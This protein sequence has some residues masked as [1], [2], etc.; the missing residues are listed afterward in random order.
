MELVCGAIAIIILEYMDSAI[1]V[2]QY[3]VN[4]IPVQDFWPAYLVMQ[5]IMEVMERS[6]MRNVHMLMELWVFLIV[7]LVY[8]V[9]QMRPHMRPQLMT[10]W[11]Y[12]EWPLQVVWVYMEIVLASMQESLKI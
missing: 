4:P 8:G 11:V 9:K 7:Q 6:D 2:R 5:R 3:L 12:M 10:V 1:I